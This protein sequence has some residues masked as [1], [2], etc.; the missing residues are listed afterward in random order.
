MDSLPHEEFS[1]LV[2]HYRHTRGLTQEEL[3]ESA[4][5]SVD[6]I[7][8]IERGLLHIPRS[9]TLQQLA[10]ALTLAPRERDEFLSAA[11]RAKAASRKT[12]VP[13]TA[14]H[15]PGTASSS[16]PLPP[17][18]LVG[19]HQDLKAARQ[20]L[21]DPLVRLLT[22][23]G[24]GGVGKT[25]FAFEL[26]R[27][28]APTVTDGVHIVY[29]APLH[30]SALV[31]AAIADVLELHET[32][33]TSIT[34]L[35][36]QHLREK[37]ALLLLDNFEHVLAASTFVA[38]ILAVSPHLKI[39]ATSRSPLHLR[40]EYNYG[41][42]PLEIPSTAYASSN[43]RLMA[44]PSVD[45]FVQRAHA[46]RPDFVLNPENAHDVAAICRLLDG[47]PLAIE[48]AAARSRILLPQALLAR[49]TSS[50]LRTLINGA[51]DL[52]AR[53]QT[54]RSTLAWSYDL[55]A[56][57]A[58]TL[59]RRLAVFAGGCTREAAEAVYA[60][61]G[62][63]PT[64]SDDMFD[65][66][67]ILVDQSLLRHRSDDADNTSRFELLETVR[68]FGWELLI[69]S[70]EL[71]TVQR[72]HACW[73][74]DL[75]THAEK[76]MRGQHAT[77]WLERL[78]A[79]RDNL[80]AALAWALHGGDLVLGLYLA[81]ALWRYWYMR[82]HFAEGRQW[83]E[84][85]LEASERQWHVLSQRPATRSWRAPPRFSMASARWR[86]RKVT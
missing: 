21:S 30:D 26:A 19:R 66:L 14:R 55:L 9:S 25:Q 84:S 56:P 57:K 78:D 18:P 73:C 80:R 32:A 82:G 52:P 46:V 17:A 3:A 23:T 42:L 54:L 61:M 86:A 29:L 83:L 38:D 13:R 11:H 58:Q 64:D 48:L 34:E 79:E 28:M 69:V 45:L 24:A 59:F 10:L 77:M 12:R 43:E 51:R 63:P 71:E 65:T 27:E 62:A 22:I 49:L 60:G 33:A 41:L 6:S 47:L 37:N 20:I 50:R 35:L 72:A 75:S 74:L 36:V 1:V 76:G 53:Q 68:E 31:P 16:I 5:V 70:G 39:L 67:A 40:G 7:S 8:N 4:N 81:P 2:K 85:L 15:T 44:I